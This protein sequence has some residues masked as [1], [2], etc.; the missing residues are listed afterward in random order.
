MSLQNELNKNISIEAIR[1]RDRIRRGPVASVD[2][3]DLFRAIIT[4]AGLNSQSRPTYDVAILEDGAAGSTTYAGLSV[5]PGQLTVTYSVG[6]HVVLWF[7]DGTQCRPVILSTG[8]GGG[9]DVTDSVI[10][11]YLGF[12]AE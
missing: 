7:P 12:L 8:S 10:T 9:G 1:S 5:Y 6:D 4:D 11:G 2:H 3:I